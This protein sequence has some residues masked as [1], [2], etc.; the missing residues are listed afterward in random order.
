[1]QMETTVDRRLAAGH[2]FCSAPS[3]AGWQAIDGGSGEMNAQ[4]HREAKR[5]KMP[6]HAAC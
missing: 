1:M 6:R 3:L 4:V 2:L 5:Q